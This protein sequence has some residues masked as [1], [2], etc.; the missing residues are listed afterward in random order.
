MT[1]V[2]AD[3]LDHLLHK[4]VG[5]MGAAVNGAL[6]VLGE[7]LGLFRALSGMERATPA[8]LAEAAGV[9]ER[10]AREWL[11]AMTAQGYVTPDETATRYHMTPEQ[12]AVFAD[13][14]SPVLLT[15]GFESVGAIYRDLDP[16]QAAFA[17]GSGL[18]WGEHNACLFC[19]TEKFFK[20]NYKAHL[21]PEW[22]PALDG[23]TE[24]LEAGARVAD[25]GCGHGASTV[26]MA[27]AY[28]ASRFEGYDFHTPSIATA[29]ERADAANVDNVSFEVRAGKEIPNGGY[30]LVCFFDCLHD[31]GDPE[32]ALR[33]AREVLKPDGA[34]M[35]VEP[36]AGDTATENLNPVGAVYY[37]FS[38]SVCVPCSLAQEKG[39]AL[40][41]QAGEARLRDVAENAGFGQWRRATE[42]PFN[43][44]LEARP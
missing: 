41:A 3:R 12:V 36:M 35:L 23:V 29:R 9:G 18:G 27:A 10:Y 31:M 24:K 38:T 15:G 7:R 33:R 37:G 11:G 28:P 17:R 13:P 2:D 44:I 4:M 22:L 25:V 40:G 32:G 16:L 42:T 14:E 8:E 20:P 30:D 26:L 43:M 6:V 1:A 19:G 39:A 5:D 21:V 34:V